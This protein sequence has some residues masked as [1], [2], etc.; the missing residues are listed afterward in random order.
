MYLGNTRTPQL[1]LIIKINITKPCPKSVLC[2]LSFIRN[3]N[4][5]CGA[6]QGIF[7]ACQRDIFMHFLCY[8]DPSNFFF[9]VCT[10]SV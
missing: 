1:L 3:L 5:F 7:G 8:M 6:S 4:R 2:S 9:P 10:P